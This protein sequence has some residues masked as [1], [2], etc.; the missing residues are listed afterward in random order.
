MSFNAVIFDLDGTLL[1]TL[2][3]LRNALNNAL[4]KRGLPARTIDD[5]RRFTGNGVRNLIA[6]VMPEN[7]SAE[8]IDSA[9]SDFR[10]YYNS[11]LN[12]ETIP[13]PGIVTMLR[14][15]KAS[16]VKVAIN[17]NKYD[18][19]LKELCAA[20]FDGLYIS[21]EG[22]SA[23]NPR[24]PDPSTALRLA[25]ICGEK[26]DNMLYI[27]DSDVDIRTAA[28]AGMTGVWVSWGFRT[29]EEMG[30]ELPENC[31]NDTKS[32]TAFILGK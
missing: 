13:Y 28:N 16:G 6:C 2:G 22:E 20:H 15:L 31:F 14:E 3:D 12:V 8:E 4:K 24:K 5:V 32:L 29:R 27:G 11:H 21:A 1:N 18:T 9:L 23:L 7:A 17:S 26:A 10:A 25:E 30:S 19:A